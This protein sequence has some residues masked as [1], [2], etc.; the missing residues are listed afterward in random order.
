MTFEEWYSV[1]QRMAEMGARHDCRVIGQLFHPG[2]VA[3]AS[4]DGS[5]MVSYAPSEVP[6]EYYKNIP[7]PLSTSQI[8]DIID[9]Y[10][11]G[12]ARMAEG[13]GDIGSTLLGTN[14][15]FALLVRNSKGI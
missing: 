8:W 9:H 12:A 11:T 10:G 7:M 1:L 13:G 5:Q 14:R 2:R 3:G 4:E 6:D 15:E